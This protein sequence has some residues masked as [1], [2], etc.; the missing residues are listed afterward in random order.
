M[1]LSCTIKSVLSL[2]IYLIIHSSNANAIE[3]KSFAGIRF[4][5]IEPG[6]FFM[7]KDT[8]IKETN[9]VE[10][11][12]HKVCISKPFY[13]GETE[14]TQKQWESVMGNNPSKTKAFYKPVDKVSWN[15]AQEFIRKLNTQ[16]NSQAFRLP[17]EAEWEYSARAGSTTLFSYGAKPNDL[18]NYAWFGDEGYGGASHEVALKKPNQWGLFDVH[19]NVWEWVQDWYDP[20]YYS[21]SPDKDPQGPVTGQYRVYRGGSWVGKA[22]NLRTSLRYSGLPVLRTNDIGLRLVHE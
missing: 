11:P 6:C 7:G 12:Q 4:V 18:S 17:T 2:S 14:V 19:G 22:I 3:Y 16:E 1:R 20:N 21:S 9:P 5:K 10:S 15:D 13:I 8:D